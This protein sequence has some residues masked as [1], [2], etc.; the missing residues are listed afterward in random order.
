MMIPTHLSFSGRQ[1]T[2]SFYQ[3][4][5]QVRVWPV[6]RWSRRFIAIVSTSP[7]SGETRHFFEEYPQPDPYSGEPPAR[8]ACAL[9]ADPR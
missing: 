5:G 6:W 8:L 2:P 1:A 7:V 9:G 3:T 4:E